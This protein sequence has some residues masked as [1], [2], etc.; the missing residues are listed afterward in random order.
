M[1]EHNSLLFG[2][3]LHD[4]FSSFS[5]NFPSHYHTISAISTVSMHQIGSLI[6]NEHDKLMVRIVWSDREN[7]YSVTAFLCAVALQRVPMSRAHLASLAK[8]EVGALL[9]V[10]TF[11]HER[12][13]CHVSRDLKTNN[14][15]TNNNIQRYHH[16]LQS[17]V[18]MA[19]NTLKDTVSQW[20]WCSLWCTLH[21]LRLSIQRCLVDIILCK[22]SYLRYA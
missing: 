4:Y 13:P 18:L 20:A 11:N 7:H 17:R 6:C 21:Y 16:W 12:A 9:S 22:V 14:N 10:L 15:W 2:G 3:E 5:A 8:R 1:S 19:H